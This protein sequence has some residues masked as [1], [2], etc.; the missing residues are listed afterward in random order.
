MCVCV[1]SVFCTCLLNLWLRCMSKFCLKQVCSVCVICVCVCVCA[2][3]RACMCVCVCACVLVL[4]VNRSLP[5]INKWHVG[6]ITPQLRPFLNLIKL[7]PPPHTHTPHTQRHETKPLV[8]NFLLCKTS[9]YLY[10]TWYNVCIW[11]HA[12]QT[13]TKTNGN[14]G[15]LNPANDV[16][17]KSTSQ[18]P[19]SKERNL[20]VCCFL[21]LRLGNSGKKIQRPCIANATK[22]TGRFT[23]KIRRMSATH[24]H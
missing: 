9:H 8:T 19:A 2:R 1:C 21:L 10:I 22:S 5:V 23:F 20:L 6:S 4:K 7:P 17:R 12:Q 15:K 3:A 18:L 11:T 14:S 16:T 24:P 13:V